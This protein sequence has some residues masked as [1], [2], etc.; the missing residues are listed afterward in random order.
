MLPYLHGR[1]AFDL[2]K[3][4]SPGQWLAVILGTVGGV[5]LLPWAPGTW[6]TLAGIA[7]AYALHDLPKLPLIIFWLS[8]WLAGSWAS[9]RID[10]VMSTEDNQNIVLDEV[11]GVGLAC[12]ALGPDPWLWL[13]A[14]LLFRLLDVLKPPPIGQIDRWSKTCAIPLL[15]GWGVMTDD[16]VAG[17]QTGLILSVVSRLRA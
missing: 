1:R 12:W 14:F 7:L 5:G 16:V 2:K 17:I 4:S 11:L 8:V 15:R 13:G 6:G 9:S 3:I 10:L